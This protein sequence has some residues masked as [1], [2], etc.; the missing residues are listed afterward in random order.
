MTRKVMHTN[1]LSPTNENDAELNKG[2]FHLA[3]RTKYVEHEKA[4]KH[5]M[6]F[7]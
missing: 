4:E 6:Q 2:N 5:D 1:E 3:I 7:S